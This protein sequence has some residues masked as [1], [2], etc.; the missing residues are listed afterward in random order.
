M[1]F[2]RFLAVL[3]FTASALSLDAQIKYRDAS[4]LPLYG[5]A[6]DSMENRYERLPD[7][8]ATSIR[9]ELASLGR[10]SAGL[11]IRFRSNSSTISARWVN[12]SAFAMPHMADTGVSG[13]D[14]YTLT[15]DGW[16]YCGTAMPRHGTVENEKVLVANMTRKER[17]FM[18]YLPLYNGV[19][20]IEIGTDEDATLE[21]PHKD[22]PRAGDQIVFYGTS[23]LQGG[24]CSRP[25]MVFTSIISRALDR[26]CINLGFSGNGRL[27]YEVAQVMA[28]VD[29]PSVFV[30]DYVPNCTAE[31]IRE[32][33]ETFFRII[34]KAHPDVPVIFID[35][36]FYGHCHVDEEARKDVDAR[37]EAQKELYLKLRKSGEKRIYHITTENTV[38]TDCEAFVDGVHF[39]DLGMMRYAENLIPVIKR[40]MR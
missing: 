12:S 4:S 23:I 19:R 29:N 11:Y 9:P 32:K 8:L 14:L 2:R 31:N 1:D 7:S 36:P 27:D 30:L 18:L 37:N 40:R 16:R 35:N 21:G 28:K 5:R 10:N 13:L 34:R 24:C 25:G 6:T 26:E 38:G 20:R 22:S 39:T 15:E 3:A 17:E 33:G